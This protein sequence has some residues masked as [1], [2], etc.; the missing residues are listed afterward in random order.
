ML[1]I[2]LNESQFAPSTPHREGGVLRVGGSNAEFEPFLDWTYEMSLRAFVWSRTDFLT[3]VI[4]TQVSIT[5][6]LK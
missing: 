5:L 1:S 2:S 6:I 3:N 4:R